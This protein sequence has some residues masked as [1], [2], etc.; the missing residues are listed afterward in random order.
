MPGRATQPG[1][2]VGWMSPSANV[3]TVP[4]PT[5]DSVASVV[6]TFHPDQRLGECIAGLVPQVGAIIVVDNGSRPGELGLDRPRSIRPQVD[7]IA[8]SENGG[9]GDALN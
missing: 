3:P 8:N 6:V 9:V 4:L 5:P 7:V 1:R 2:T